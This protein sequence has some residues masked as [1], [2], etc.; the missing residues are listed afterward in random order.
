MGSFYFLALWVGIYIIAPRFRKPMLVMSSILMWWGLY[1]EYYWWTTDWW[2][3]ATITNTRIGIEDVIVSFTHIGVPLFL[4]KTL[5]DQNSY[6]KENRFSVF[7]SVKRFLELMLVSFVPASI[8]F[9]FFDIHSFFSTVIGLLLA[10]SFILFKRGDLFQEIIWTTFLMTLA[11]IPMYLLGSLLSPG[12]MESFWNLPKLSGIFIAEIPLEDL[13]WYA[14]FGYFLGGLH[15]YLLDAKLTESNEK[16][17]D[18][19]QILLCFIYRK[20]TN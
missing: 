19:I 12:I 9:Y 6:L 3:P 4:Y 11:A 20:A 1:F 17:L 18:R 8:L 5:F 15:E 7:A 2:H 16:W 13:V 14:A 10:G